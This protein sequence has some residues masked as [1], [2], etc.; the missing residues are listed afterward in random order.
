MVRESTRT[1][2]K[3]TSQQL[4]ATQ[5]NSQISIRRVLSANVA[6]PPVN[7]TQS[8][9]LEISRSAAE[10]GTT[11]YS[12]LKKR[13]RGLHRLVFRLTDEY[14]TVMQRLAERGITPSTLAAARQ[15]QRQR[16]HERKRKR[17]RKREYQNQSAFPRIRKVKHIPH[18]TPS[19][20]IKQFLVISHQL[21]R[22]AT[23]THSLLFQICGTRG[24]RPI[25]RRTGVKVIGSKAGRRMWLN[26]GVKGIIGSNA[27]R[28]DGKQ[29]VRRRVRRRVRRV[30]VGTK[31]VVR[32]YIS[33]PSVT[34]THD[35]TRR[36]GHARV[37]KVG[38][39][40]RMER[41]QLSP[42]RQ[43]NKRRSADKRNGAKELEELAKSWLS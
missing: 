22:L 4:Q 21:A 38:V 6:E 11:V 10:Q 27:R 9:A 5:G 2:K 35:S 42:R 24:T 36:K 29:Q 8:S 14:N 26:L 16:Q 41:M 17:K 37:R 39:G 40:R 30:T 15:H 1:N 34:R 33:A 7:E 31:R 25:L 3:P 23:F 32:G 18:G 13:H 20:I 43:A 12:Y 19:S 28:S